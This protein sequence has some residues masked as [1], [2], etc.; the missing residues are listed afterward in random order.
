[1]NLLLC[2]KSNMDPGKIYELCECPSC[3]KED[4]R[5]DIMELRPCN[6]CELKHCWQCV[7]MFGGLVGGGSVCKSCIK[8]KLKIIP[9]G[10][11]GL[12]NVAT[13]P[14]TKND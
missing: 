4:K 5:T 9:T 14:I 8:M 1:M 7:G 12:F 13:V 2:D 3:E 11:D 6:K 10:R